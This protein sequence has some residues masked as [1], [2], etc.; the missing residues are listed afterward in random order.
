MFIHIFIKN[1]YKA[2][3]LNQSPTDYDH[4]GLKGKKIAG[5]NANSE[6]CRGST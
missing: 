3:A 5:I 6:V 1:N 2:N 4:F